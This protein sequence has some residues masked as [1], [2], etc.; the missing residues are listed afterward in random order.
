SPGG[1]GGWPSPPSRMKYCPLQL[2]NVDIGPSGTDALITWNARS[3]AGSELTL[4]VAGGEI[5]LVLGDVLHAEATLGSTPCE[6]GYRIHQLVQRVMPEVIMVM[7][8]RKLEESVIGRDMYVGVAYHK[9]CFA[10]VWRADGKPH[11]GMLSWSDR[12][13]YCIA[14]PSN[15]TFH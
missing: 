6:T 2:P 14:L 5:G 11:D 3:S 4:H 9:W 1:T 7:A 12:I 13:L 8:G 15:E 10:D